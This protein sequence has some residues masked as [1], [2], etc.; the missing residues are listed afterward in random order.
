MITKILIV[1]DNPLVRQQ[2]SGIIKK[3]PEMELTGEAENGKMAVFMAK[4][5]KPDMI[6]MDISMP[7]MN[8]IEATIRI[9]DQTPAMK[10]IATSVHYQKVIVDNI[11]NNGAAGFVLKDFLSDELLNAIETVNNQ[12]VYMSPDVEKQRLYI[13]Q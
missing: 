11:L 13:N 6:I 2:L 9:K 7:V 12:S 5:M 10:I 8:G 4:K 3:H 1:D